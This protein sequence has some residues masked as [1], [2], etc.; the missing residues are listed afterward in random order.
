MEIINNGDDTT[1]I[2][3]GCDLGVLNDFPEFSRLCGFPMTLD[4]PVDY[5]EGI[6]FCQT[7][8]VYDGT[9][10]FMMRDPRV[11]LAKDAVSVKHFDDAKTYDLLRNSIGQCGKA[12]AGHMPIFKSFY[13]MFCRGAGNRVDRDLEDTGFKILARGM[14][15]TGVVTDYARYSF[16]LAF[17]IT[18]DEQKALE[19]YYDKVN[20]RWVKPPIV[21]AFGKPEHIPR[22]MGSPS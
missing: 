17:G 19:E 11:C 5:L 3:E 18:P 2:L 4:E 1:A 22:A 10:W 20:L 12:L 16:Y 21:T 14:W 8:P 13:A 15:N 9:D 7:H 6:E